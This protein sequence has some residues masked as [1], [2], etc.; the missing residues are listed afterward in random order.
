MVRL[1]QGGLMSDAR[2]ILKWLRQTRD[3]PGFSPAGVRNRSCDATH[4]AAPNESGTFE[5]HHA[6]TGCYA[7]P[8]R[9]LDEV[10]WSQPRRCRGPE[11]Q[12]AWL[13]LA[14][15]MTGTL[16]PWNSMKP[17]RL[18]CV[19]PSATYW[20]IWE[21]GKYV[22]S[23]SLVHGAVQL[24]SHHTQNTRTCLRRRT[25][26][27]ANQ[28]VLNRPPILNHVD[29]ATQNASSFADGTVSFQT[30]SHSGGEP[31]ETPPS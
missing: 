24:C 14:V 15:I 19:A 8:A 10:D 17:S 27:L 1:C 16:K 18:A 13:A 5:S 28:P 9:G 31:G 20:L 7:A 4:V 29:T 26:V 11:T 25:D 6:Q 23:W 22:Y 3:G 21:N 30:P 2:R 12:W